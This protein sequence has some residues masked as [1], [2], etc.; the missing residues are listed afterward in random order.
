MMSI[1]DLEGLLREHTTVAAL[2]TSRV[3]DAGVKPPKKDKR[4]RVQFR[5][6]LDANK[7][8]EAEMIRF[9]EALQS[10]RQFKPTLFDALKHYMESQPR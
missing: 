8:E 1:A 3:G 5:I 2:P 9:L 6:W 4:H 10:A 7:S